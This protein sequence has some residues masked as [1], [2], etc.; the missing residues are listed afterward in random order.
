MKK[1][2]KMSQLRQLAS[3]KKKT[4]AIVQKNPESKD[5]KDGA[6]S[7]AA[8]AEA[9]RKTERPPSPKLPS[10]TFL[11]MKFPPRSTL[12]SV[13]NLK[14]RFARFGPLDLLGTRVS[15]KNYSCR[16]L[17]RHKSDAQSAVDFVQNN[18]L[19]GQVKVGYYLRDQEIST[20]D[21]PFDPLNKPSDSSLPD[22]ESLQYRL[23]NAGIQKPSFSQAQ[24][25]QTQLKSILKK[26]GGDESSSNYAAATI[27][28]TRESPRVKFMLNG[29]DDRISDPPSK[30]VTSSNNGGSQAPSS[31]STVDQITRQPPR[32][33]A[34]FAPP[35]SQPTQPP[36]RGL[37]MHPNRAP[38]P[39]PASPLP[40]LPPPRGGAHFHPSRGLLPPNEPTEKMAVDISGPMLSLL[41]KCNDI[42]GDVK[43]SLGYNPYHSL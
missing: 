32:S 23:G 13:S 43:S 11:I 35:L 34:S 20:P 21:Q 29:D 28:I 40:P 16:V 42:V 14:A 7:A 2:E 18:D 8:A 19:F 24:Q 17:F 36:S 38:P 31:L 12:P 25:S 33:I 37:E 10:P 6:S 26:P 5:Q 27:A 1:M 3:K 4:A 9:S 22:K 15:W 39:S 41:L 30:L